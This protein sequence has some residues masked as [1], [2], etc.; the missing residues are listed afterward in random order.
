MVDVHIPETDGKK[1]TSPLLYRSFFF[2]VRQFFEYYFPLRVSLPL[3]L[4][5]QSY[6]CVG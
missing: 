5:L 2:E 6:F 4:L 1:V 3:E